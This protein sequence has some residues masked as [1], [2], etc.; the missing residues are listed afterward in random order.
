MNHKK[1]NQKFPFHPKGKKG[2]SII[3]GYILL[4][5]VVITISIIV[6]QWLKN[7]VPSDALT[8]PDS[9]SVSVASYSCSG[10]ILNFSLTNTGTFSIAGYFIHAGKSGSQISTTNLAPYYNASVGSNAGQKAGGGIMFYNCG[11]S[12]CI[13]PGNTYTADK[14]YFNLSISPSVTAST[15]AQ[16]TI[17][18][19]RNVE[20]QN[21][22]QTASCTSAA[23]TVPIKCS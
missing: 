2:V 12:N 1:K 5:A 6:Y 3:I 15:L 18:P 11:E 16:I 4:V 9:V 20:Y 8:C 21:Q 19:V 10:N 23:I 7:Y 13:A 14:N 17:T 22:L